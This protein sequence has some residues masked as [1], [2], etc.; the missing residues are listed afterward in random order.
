MVRGMRSRGRQGPGGT[1][2]GM[3]EFEHSYSD[4]SPIGR[5]HRAQVETMLS[6]D[7]AG[8]WSCRVVA[9]VGLT[10]LEATGRGSTEELAALDAIAELA[11][12]GVEV[13][14]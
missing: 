9:Q 10:R 11:A 6:R 12:V 7:D 8:V 4:A 14:E 5:L 1:I 3:T 2:A 13:P